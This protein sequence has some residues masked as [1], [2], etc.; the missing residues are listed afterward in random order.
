MADA[1]RTD[2]GFTLVELLVAMTLL[3]FLMILLFGS[4]KFGSRAWERSQ[5]VTADANFVRAAQGALQDAI[6][7]AYP[8]GQTCG[9][10][11]RAVAFDGEEHD[12]TLLS[13]AGNGD[14]GMTRVRVYAEASD[15]SLS[16]AR[17]SELAVDAAI[18]TQALLHGAAD[19]DFRYYGQADGDRT[20]AWHATWKSQRRLPQLIRVH[21]R[22]TDP[23]MSWPDL[24]VAPKIT[25]A[26]NC[27]VDLLSHDCQGRP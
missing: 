11:C 13:L 22:L 27:V 26:M 1:R 14:G 6:E 25:A 2:D 4:L 12:L 8:L 18:H 20:P 23:R 24:I 19:L 10:G 3:G 7:H 16:L 5:E 15:S 17:S 21:L 9:T